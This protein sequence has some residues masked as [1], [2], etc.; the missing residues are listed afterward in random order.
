MQSSILAWGMPWME[1]PGRLQSKGLKQSD[2]TEAPEHEKI[3]LQSFDAKFFLLSHRIPL[4]HQRVFTKFSHPVSFQTLDPLNS[5]PL[6]GPVVLCFLVCRPWWLRRWR[7]CL[8]CRGPGFDPWVGKIPWR[9]EWQP[10]PVFL[11][12]KLQG[13]RRLM[14]YSRW[15]HKEPNMTERLTL[16]LF[17]LKHSFSM[18]DVLPFGRWL[19]L[20]ATKTKFL[21]WVYG[22]TFLSKTSISALLTMPKPLTVWVTINC[23][24]FWKRWEYQTTWPASCW[25]SNS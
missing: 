25:G 4:L 19:K 3:R 23:G 8:Q 6:T 11:P 5:D 20:S 7:I 21:C 12:W 17:L 13:Q 10:T 18:E 22:L 9:R 2:A 15:G 16:Y 24:K 14:G 1:E